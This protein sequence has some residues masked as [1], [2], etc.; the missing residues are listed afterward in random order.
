MICL[1]VHL[2]GTKVCRAGVGKYGLVHVNAA[3]SHLPPAWRRKDD[4]RRF[5]NF[6]FGVSGVR[7]AARPP[8]H[9]NLYW[10]AGKLSL[11][12][13][14]RVQCIETPTADEPSVRDLSERISDRDQMEMI[15]SRLAGC[16]NDLGRLKGD[17]AKAMGRELR[18]LLRKSSK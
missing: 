5:P 2:N 9:E 15:R 8:I 6:P 3:W 18:A 11:G 10:H 14:L 16:A 12:D 4:D 1:D 17:E 7:Y 13:D